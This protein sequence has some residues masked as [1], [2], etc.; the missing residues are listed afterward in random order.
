MCFKTKPTEGKKND[1]TVGFHFW[2]LVFVASAHTRTYI[3]DISSTIA[4]AVEVYCI[5]RYFLIKQIGAD[6]GTNSKVKSIN[7]IIWSVLK[8]YV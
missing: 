1:I 4:V 2:K 3:F 7:I 8:R 6:K 5:H